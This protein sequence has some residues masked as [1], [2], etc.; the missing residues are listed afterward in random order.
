MLIVLLFVSLCGE[1]RMFN[2][3]V[4]CILQN[5]LDSRTEHMQTQMSDM[6]VQLRTLQ[7]PGSMSTMLPLISPIHTLRCFQIYDR[8]LPVLLSSSHV[9]AH[10]ATVCYTMNG[11]QLCWCLGNAR[12]RN[13]QAAPSDCRAQESYAGFCQERASFLVW[14][15]EWICSRDVWCSPFT[16]FL[17]WSTYSIFCAL[18]IIVMYGA[19]LSLQG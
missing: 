1:T 12:G 10:M 8:S 6:T 9:N 13:G 5:L 19:L 15:I 11:K 18:N 2:L 7:V 17:V 16:A 4:V 14:S 3:S